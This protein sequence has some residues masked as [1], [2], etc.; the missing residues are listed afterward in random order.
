MGENDNCTKIEAKGSPAL[1]LKTVVSSR[2]TVAAS[3]FHNGSDSVSNTTSKLHREHHWEG[4]ALKDSQR[5]EYK[6]DPT[7]MNQ[8]TFAHCI[9]GYLGEGGNQDDKAINTGSKGKC[10][11]NYHC[12]RI[13]RLASW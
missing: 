1:F 8:Y 3:S 10:A 7:S 4:V 6:R 5:E 12:T 9:N 13:G 2:K 11:S